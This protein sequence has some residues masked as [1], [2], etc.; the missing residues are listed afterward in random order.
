MFEHTEEMEDFC[1]R[2]LEA[3]R[4]EL[5]ASLSK[6][7]DIVIE[8]VP[9]EMDES[10]LA[11]QRDLAVYNL[12]REAFILRLVSKALERIAAGEYG[13]CMEC[14]EPVS[15]KRLLALPWAALC[16]KCQETADRGHDRTP[17]RG[18]DSWLPDAA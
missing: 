1:R 11:N 9:D 7:K 5:T 8:R 15:V 4:A 2:V 10:V 17:K 13:I 12:N 3:K 6:A 14:E 18:R 16:L